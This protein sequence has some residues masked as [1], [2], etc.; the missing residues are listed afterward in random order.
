MTKKITLSGVF[1]PIPLEDILMWHAHEIKTCTRIWIH[2]IIELSVLANGMFLNPKFYW[3]VADELGFE[4]QI[5]AYNHIKKTVA[6]LKLEADF[7]GY[8][9][10]DCGGGSWTQS[11]VPCDGEETYWKGVYEG[12][13]VD[14]SGS[15]RPSCDDCG[16]STMEYVRNVKVNW[17]TKEGEE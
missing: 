13:S 6:Q 7:T 10:T 12:S 1:D 8:V 16:T 4:S 3:R 9:C 15:E 17:S 5:E 2:K 11:G 14:F